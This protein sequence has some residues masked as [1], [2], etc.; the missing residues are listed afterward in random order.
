MKR[1][2]ILF[3]AFVVLGLCATSAQA[4]C[5]ASTISGTYGFVSQG[6]AGKPGDPL[7]QFYAFV[8]VGT[9]TFNADGTVNRPATIS[10]AGNLD[11]ATTS[12]TYTVNSD[13]SG[14]M[15][16]N[17]PAGVE[18]FSFTIVQK[19]NVILFINTTENILPKLGFVQSGRAE[20]Q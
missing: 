7:Q 12:G 9:M 16:F 10:F 2:L 3:F 18:T 4:S 6:Y 17:V 8:V 15:A 1:H 14:T 19:G 11:S 5:T 13:C 20:K